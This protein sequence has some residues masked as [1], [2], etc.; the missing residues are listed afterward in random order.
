[1]T[2]GEKH[3]TN[4]RRA[5]TTV[6][7]GDHKQA[8]S[9]IALHYLS[10]R[11]QDPMLYVVSDILTTLRRLFVYHPCL[12]QRFVTAVRHFN[13]QVC[14]PAT[15]LASYLC[16]LGWE[17]TPNAT[18]IGPGGLRIGIQCS[19]SKTIKKE[20]RI[21]WDWHC[22]NEIAHRKGVTPLPF[23]S[24]TANK[25]LR[26]FSDKQRRILALS[27]TAGWQS[28]GVISQWSAHQTPNCPFCDQYDTHKHFILE[29]PCFNH[30]R[31]LHQK[32]VHHLMANT[33]LCWFP[34]P[35]HSSE[36][37]LIRQAMHS[38]HHT[39]HINSQLEFGTDDT[40]YTDGSC[41]NPRSPFVARAA[42]AV[43]HRT[44]CRNTPHKDYDYKVLAS[45]HCPGLQTINRAEL[46]AMLIAA[47]QAR[48]SN[49]QSQVSFYTD[50]Q[51][52][53]NVLTHIEANTIHE[54][55]HKRDHWDLIVRLC[56]AWDQSRFHVFKIKSH[57][58]LENAHSTVEAYHI[59]GNTLADEAAVRTCTA[60]LPDFLAVCEQV[61]KHYESQH[62]E[63]TAIYKY[64][65]D[66]SC[67]RMNKLEDKAPHS[68]HRQAET[69]ETNTVAPG[70]EQNAEQHPASI[71]TH[72]FSEQVAFL[73]DWPAARSFFVMP[74]EP[75]RVVFW[76][77]PWGCNYA[78]LVWRYCCMLQ[79][80]AESAAPVPK[81]PGISW[82]ELTVS[83]MLWAGRLLP[84]RVTNK[85]STEI[86]DYHDPKTTLQPTKHKSVR[87]L[88]ETFRLIVK[89]IQTFSRTKILPTYKLQ[90]ASS[91][92][93]LGFSRY[94]ESGISRRPVLPNSQETYRYLQDLV[95]TISHNPPFHNE[96]LPLT[97]S[98]KENSPPWPEWPEIAIHKRE[99]FTQHIRYYLFRKKSFDLVTHPGPN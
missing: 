93:R 97:I 72:S 36:L 56:Q 51:F 10:S 46:Y 92:T 66:L 7:V 43:I 29:C 2:I 73:R 13:G 81:D 4:L 41:Q 64:L 26:Q 23:D 79:W 60:D 58:H 25:I 96:I 22:H 50:S 34:L 85:N 90:G 48:A 59:L 54:S 15:A 18:L 95:L 30:I 68:A 40:I 37:E 57:L 76:S 9:H 12:A 38:R 82:T 21:A 67:E 91:L 83:F 24:W 63:L 75:H 71:L 8:S 42:W 47:E 35:I 55:P 80:P 27:L 31:E 11:I 94:H 45:G 16:R 74:D 69:A 6:L 62:T 49:D 52:V 98:L 84:I 33:Y 61:Q 87:V 88:A 5:A 17:L 14:G 32:A 77:C 19:T 44:R 28:N 86:L 78:R 89:H 1:M 39:I 20:L 3:F 53:V 70:A 99:K 65:L